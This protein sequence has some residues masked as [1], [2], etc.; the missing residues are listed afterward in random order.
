LRHLLVAAR[1][2]GFIEQNAHAAGLTHRDRTVLCRLR[3]AA[4]CKR[5]RT[6]RKTG[7]ALHDVRPSCLGTR[8]DPSWFRLRGMRARSS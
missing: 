6:M 4:G 1:D 8:R 3:G 7:S 5:L 2:G